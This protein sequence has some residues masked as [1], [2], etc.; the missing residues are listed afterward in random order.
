MRNVTSVAM[1]K[2]NHDLGLLICQIPAVN[3]QTIYGFEPTVLEYGFG[4]RPIALRKLCRKQ[5]EQ[6]I[7]GSNGLCQR[8]LADD[9]TLLL[10]IAHCGS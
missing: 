4:R 8:V 6:L 1:G 10:Q 5:C 3:T 7:Y 9:L 2:Q